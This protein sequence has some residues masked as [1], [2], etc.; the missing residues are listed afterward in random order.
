MPVGGGVPTQ[1]THIQAPGL[2]ASISPDNQHIASF[3][4][5]G[6]FVMKP[7]GTGLTMIVN[8]VGGIAGTVNWIP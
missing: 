5:N 8:D 1:L 3:S 6:V 7:D 4:G 2:Y